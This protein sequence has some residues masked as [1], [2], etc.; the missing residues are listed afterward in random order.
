MKLQYNQTIVPPE[1]MS[2]EEII[3]ARA[4]VEWDDGEKDD[5]YISLMDYDEGSNT[6]TA[7]VPDDH[8]AFYADSLEHLKNMKYRGHAPFKILDYKLVTMEG[9]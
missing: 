8:I 3:G 6:D 4:F 2:G 1:L 7:G 5:I 9:K